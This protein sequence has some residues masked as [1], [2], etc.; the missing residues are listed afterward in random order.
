MEK[1]L[2]IIARILIEGSSN[3]LEQALEQIRVDLDIPVIP[4][5]VIP[6]QKQ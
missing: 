3:E 2:Y 6:K 1:L 5:K 4:E